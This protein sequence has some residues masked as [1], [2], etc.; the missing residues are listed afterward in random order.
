M[1]FGWE[2]DMQNDKIFLVFTDGS[3]I[4][5]RLKFAQF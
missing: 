5:L 1:N 3:F 4:P 2:K